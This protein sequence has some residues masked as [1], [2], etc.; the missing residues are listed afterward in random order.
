MSDLIDG[1]TL[2]GA[3]ITVLK[4]FKVKNMRFVCC[5]IDEAEALRYWAENCV[6]E[7]CRFKG[8]LK[9]KS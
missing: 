5:D 9:N 3:N 2:I 4:G 1:G 6:F 8:K 7:K